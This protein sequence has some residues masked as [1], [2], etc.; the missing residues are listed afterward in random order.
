VPTALFAAVPEVM[1]RP[2]LAGKGMAVLTLGQNL[3]FVVGPVF[4]NSLVQTLGC[5]GAGCARAPLMLVTAAIGWF[6]R[7]R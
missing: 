2:D 3:G 1:E 5:V 7:V 6:A 4:F